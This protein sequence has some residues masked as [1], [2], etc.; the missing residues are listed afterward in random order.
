[1]P[2]ATITTTLDEME[3]RLPT[4]PA[5]LLRLERSLA[6]RTY[7]TMSGA[8]GSVRRSADT[9]VQRTGRALRTVAGTARHAV[10]TTVDVARIGARTTAGQAQAQARRVRDAATGA[11]ADLHDDA[12]GSVA[13]ATQVLDADDDATTGYDRWTKAELYEKA[14]E[15][16]I[17]GRSSM[18]KDEL[19]EA[20]R[21]H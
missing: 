6:A 11:V 20:I 4:L 8:A 9:V 7:D 18:T 16:E 10:D 14:A 3:E 1:M 15:L 2:T 12:V 5:R 19:V 21:T 13:S 17:E